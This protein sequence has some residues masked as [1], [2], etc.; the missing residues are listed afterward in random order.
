MAV[1]FGNHL[2]QTCLAVEM[3]LTKMQD[4]ALKNSVNATQQLSS[5]DKFQQVNIQKPKRPVYHSFLYLAQRIAVN[6][7]SLK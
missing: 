6:F 1:Q 7:Y 4:L 2:S 3:K 5:G